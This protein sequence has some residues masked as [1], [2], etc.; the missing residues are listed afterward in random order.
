MILVFPV[1]EEQGKANRPFI[2]KITLTA[3]YS[4][5]RTTFNHK[6]T[7]GP[8]SEDSKHSGKTQGKEGFRMH[9]HK[10]HLE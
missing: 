10:D 8:E 3:I 5:A 2:R 7:R 1:E 9:P 4:S 6:I